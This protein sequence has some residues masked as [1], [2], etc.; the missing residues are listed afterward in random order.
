MEKFHV[1]VN[2]C[3]TINQAKAKILDLIYKNTPYSLRPTIQDFDLE[4]RDPAGNH[5]LLHDIDHTSKREHTGWQRLNSLKHYNVKNM[6]LVMLITKHSLVRHNGTLY[7]SGKHKSSSSF[8]P[9]LSSPVGCNSMS[10][11]VT[12]VDNDHYWHLVKP[13]TDDMSKESSSSSSGSVLMHKAIPE[14]FLTRLLSTKG[15][16]QKFVDDFFH[17]ILVVNDALP[18]MLLS[19]FNI[20]IN[21]NPLFV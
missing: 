3:D 11:F 15:T 12:D 4:W 8:Y 5:H 19:R 14:I 9:L 16:I 21:F 18:G 13:T 1:R 10:T 17:T 20:S 2:D 7:M 6:A